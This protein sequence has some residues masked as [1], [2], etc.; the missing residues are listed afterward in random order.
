[1]SDNG[2]SQQN[3]SD[4][5]KLDKSDNGKT[6]QNPSEEPKVD[7]MSDSQQIASD[8]PNSSKMSEFEN[9]LK[10]EG[11]EGLK[12]AFRVLCPSEDGQCTLE[13]GHLQRAVKALGLDITEEKAKEIIQEFSQ[14]GLFSCEDFVD[15]VK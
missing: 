7:K 12:D 8:D 13:Y 6:Q 10:K 1:M 9:A 4:E 14:Q 2:K 3:P 15:I 5:P 11:D